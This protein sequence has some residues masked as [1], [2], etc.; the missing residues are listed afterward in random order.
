MDALQFF[1]SRELLRLLSSNRLNT[2]LKK[3]KFFDWLY[4]NSTALSK[5]R[6]SNNNRIN[7][8][9]PKIKHQHKNSRLINHLYVDISKYFFD[10]INTIQ[11]WTQSQHNLRYNQYWIALSWLAIGWRSHR[12]KAAVDRT[13]WIQVHPLV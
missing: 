11:I 8:R 10:F 7:D 6:H 5:Q 9:L 13:R 12:R 1:G 4:A 2:I 3:W